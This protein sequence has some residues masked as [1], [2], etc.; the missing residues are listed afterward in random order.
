M[1]YHVTLPVQTVIVTETQSNTHWQTIHKI[2]T[3]EIQRAKPSTG[4]Q[5][6]AFL[7]VSNRE[8]P[9][10]QQATSNHR[11]LTGSRSLSQHGSSQA[12]L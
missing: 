11:G 6:F 8:K 2:Y 9:L 3:F 5:T 4:H 7:P 12:I 10:E 1:W